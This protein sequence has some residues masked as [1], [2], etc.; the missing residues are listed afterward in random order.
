[1]ILKQFR[2]GLN[3]FHFD[4]A[5]PF[6]EELLRRNFPIDR[7]YFNWPMNGGFWL[8]TFTAYGISAFWDIEF[9]D[10][11]GMLEFMDKLNTED[12]VTEAESTEFY[13]WMLGMVEAKDHDEKD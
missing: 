6:L 4:D 10:K 11:A 2:V 8:L 5:E 3:F 1:M 7:C 12:S 13:Q 9:T